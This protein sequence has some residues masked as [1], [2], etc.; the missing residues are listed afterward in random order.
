MIKQSSTTEFIRQRRSVRRYQDDPIP[1]EILLDIINCGRLAPSAHN[2]Q[3][4]LIGVVNDP[5]LCGAIADLAEN[6]QFIR[7]APVCFAVFTRSSEK[8]YLEDGCAATMNIILAAAAHGISTCWVAGDKKSYAQAVCRILDVPDS[9]SLISLIPAGYS[10][11]IP[12]PSKVPFE[13]IVFYNRREKQGDKPSD[14]PERK[15]GQWKNKI[16]RKAKR[17]IRKTLK[18]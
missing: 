4:W 7:W 17:K 5:D 11:H 12:S 3:P 1:Q 10:A 8:Y 6:G 14:S 2:N 18:I 9:Y 16:L 13:E 15:S